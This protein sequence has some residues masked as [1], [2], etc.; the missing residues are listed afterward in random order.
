LFFYFCL[1]SFVMGDVEKDFQNREKPSMTFTVF[2]DAFVYNCRF[3][4]RGIRCSC[5][6]VYD[7][8]KVRFL[9]YILSQIVT[10]QY[11]HNP[12]DYNWPCSIINDHDWQLWKGNR[13]SISIVQT[14][15]KMRSPNIGDLMIN[16]GNY[17]TVCIKE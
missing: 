14:Y 2:I 17:T 4:T 1:W 9:F 5:D 13:P 16:D 6:K 12:L 15:P 8:Q 7:K 11:I 10:W 3:T